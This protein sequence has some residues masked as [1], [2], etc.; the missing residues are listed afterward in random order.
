MTGNVIFQEVQNG[1][2]KEQVDCYV[3]KI[4]KEYRFAYGE[5]LEMQSKYNRL[6]IEKE[7]RGDFVPVDSNSPVLN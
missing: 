3:N 7:R 2:S 6:L 4:M 5:Y 1:Y